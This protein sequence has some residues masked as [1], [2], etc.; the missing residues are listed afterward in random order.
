[1]FA[2]L[3]LITRARNNFVEIV[4]D[5]ED[6]LIVNSGIKEE[7]VPNMPARKF[8]W[9]KDVNKKRKKFLRTSST[10]FSV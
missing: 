6:Y 9:W 10:K 8:S 1:M 7:A 4:A 2:Q 3:G 5:S